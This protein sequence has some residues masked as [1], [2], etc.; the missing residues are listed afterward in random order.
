MGRITAVCISEK[1]GTVKKN[2]GSCRLIEDFGLEND[3]HAG[4]TRQVSLLSA[5]QVEAFRKRSQGAVDLPPG[6]FGENLLV[7][8]FDFKTYPVGT[9]FRTGEVL[10]ELTQIGKQCHTGCEIMKK[11][12]E[13]IMPHEGVFARVLSGG[14]VKAGDELTRMFNAA[15]LVASDR[16][17]RGEYTDESGPALRKALESADFRVCSETILSDDEDG[18]VEALKRIAD[19]ERPDVIFTSGGTGFS[20]RDRMPEATKRVIDREAPGISEA[21]RAYSMTITKKAMLS[22]ATSGMRGRTL[23]VN[24][25]G[26]PKAVR[27]CME[28]LLPPLAHGLAILS[29]EGDA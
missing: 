22:R 21:V 9:R 12:G 27:E 6:I 11:T 26:S 16:A 5:D 14:V 25:P 10:L 29:G 17:S 23:I 7:E 19:E 13:C 20:L 18:L 2:V 24:L 3:A 4:S 1:K 8:G 28:F 15:I